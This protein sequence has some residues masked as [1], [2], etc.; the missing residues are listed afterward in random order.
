MG[1]V[2]ARPDTQLLQPTLKVAARSNGDHVQVVHMSA[3]WPLSRRTDLPAQRLRE[4]AREIPAL[5]CVCVH[6]CQFHAQDGGLQF[7][8]PGVVT[9]NRAHIALGPSILP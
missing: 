5:L 9:W 1:V 3:A 8:E 6:M 7:V 4:H 2:D